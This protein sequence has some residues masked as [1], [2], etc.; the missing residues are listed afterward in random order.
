MQDNYV[1]AEY[2]HEYKLMPGKDEEDPKKKFLDPSQSGFELGNDTLEEMADLMFMDDG[3]GQALKGNNLD[4]SR[5]QK[6]P[7]WRLLR[8]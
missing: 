6:N 1:F 2:W 3:I 7:L 8:I 5:L 4:T